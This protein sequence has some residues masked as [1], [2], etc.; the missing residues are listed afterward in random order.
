MS[1]LDATPHCVP[2]ANRLHSICDLPHDVFFLILSSL[3]S[4]DIARCIAVCRSFADFIHSDLSLQYRIELAQNGMID[5]ESSTLPVSE[6]LERLRQYS[7]NFK[8][9]AFHH[10]DLTAHP[11]Y[12]F[13]NRNLLGR[14]QSVI[15]PE[16]HSC[17]LYNEPEGGFDQDHSVLY[18]SLF[19]P[20]SA[21]GGIPS[22]RSLFTIR[23]AVKPDMVAETWAMDYSEDLF[24]MVEMTRISHQEEIDG[25]I[26]DVYI[27]F[28]S[29]SGLK[30]D[31][32]T[33][34]P[35]STL[36]FIHLPIVGNSAKPKCVFHLQIVRDYVIF[37]IRVEWGDFDSSHYIDV[38]NWK[39]GQMVSV[40]IAASINLAELTPRR[41]QLSR[42]N[43]G[44]ALVSIVPLHEPYLLLLPSTRMPKL[45]QNPSVRI[46]SFFPSSDKSLAGRHVCTLQLPPIPPEEYMLW[47]QAR[48]GDRTEET[49][50]HFRA[51][52]SRSV[53]ALY[54][55]LAGT[56]IEN[57]YTT[58]LLVPR[59][60][61][62]AH[63]HAAESTSGQTGPGRDRD[64]G[65]GTGSEAAPDQPEPMPL[66]V[67]WADWGPRGCLRLHL[68]GPLFGSLYHGF[69]TPFGSRLPVVIFDGPENASASMYVFDANP[70]VARS[71]HRVGTAPWREHDKFE[72]DSKGMN[73]DNADAP[74]AAH[75]SAGTGA[76]AVVEDIE[77][78]L[79]G[80]VDL[81][82]A[83]IPYAVY[84][85]PLPYSRLGSGPVV[86]DICTVMMSMAGFTVQLVFDDSVEYEKRFQTST[87]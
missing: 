72:T 37:E 16:R 40:R 29:L 42:T 9:G 14:L 73:E 70:L 24:V 79:P 50:G 56:E 59:T 84:R 66:S 48:T 54:T 39:T 28:Y 35:A 74:L 20:G 43:V 82:C 49:T 46:Y 81:Q 6:R 83:A 65:L 38:H 69:W 5:G 15:P 80:V 19:V 87:V 86:P 30:T 8:S 78:V 64:A 18:L 52:P 77:E 32:M 62:A 17:T 85:F 63:I 34:H 3:H 47:S 27:R 33:P 23:G 22:S 4:Q 1:T 31:T 71:L 36:P 57:E 75:R 76:T 11:D 25:R 60:T 51:D 68:Q 12:V 67:P 7:S 21:Q 2:K 61:L 10:E 41:H 44:D 55:L 53:V 13:P 26:P 58:C 45:H